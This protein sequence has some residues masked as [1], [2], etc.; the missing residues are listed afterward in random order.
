MSGEIILDYFKEHPEADKNG[1][2][3]IQ[4]VMLQGEPGHQDATL[5]SQYCIEAITNDGT[6]GVEELAADTAMWDKVKATDLMKTFLASHGADKI[7]AVFANNDDM[8]LG[9]IDACLDAG[10]TAEEL[11]QLRELLREDAL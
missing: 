11:A 8:A 1:D 10:L 6:F 5:R 2:G 3:K 4:Y 9:A 7:E